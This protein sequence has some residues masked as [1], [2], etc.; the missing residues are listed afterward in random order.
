MLYASALD[1]LP[2]DLGSTAVTFGKFDG[3]H[4]GHRA[5]V[6]ELVSLAGERSL[7]S[8]VLTFDRNPLSLLAPERSPERVVSSRQKRRLLAE[9]GVALTVEIPFDREFSLLTAEQF[10]DTVLIGALNAALVLVGPET[11]FGAGGAGSFDTLAALG[12]ERGVEVMSHRLVSAG[13]SS[14]V[15]STRIRALLTVGDVAGATALLGRVPS[16]RAEVVHG[17]RRGRELGYPTANLSPDLEGFIPADGVYAGYLTW[18]GRRMPAAISVGDNPTFVGV[19]AR[20][21]EAYVIDEDL[22]LYDE[23]VE[24]EFVKR[25]RGQLKFDALEPLIAQMAL[26]TQRARELTA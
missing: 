20:Q 10:V 14:P 6:D 24:V 16:V 8:T 25:L 5:V 13:G 18:N 26:D 3:I 9:A 22:D 12:R 11:R 2:A 23:I 19:P 4:L 7:V 21:V 1:Q 17:Q 15:S